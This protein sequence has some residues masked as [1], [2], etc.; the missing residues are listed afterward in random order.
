MCI[1]S[2]LLQRMVP[3]SKEKIIKKKIKETKIPTKEENNGNTVMNPL[4]Y[5]VSWRCDFY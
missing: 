4:V 2:L 5:G 3:E 1:S